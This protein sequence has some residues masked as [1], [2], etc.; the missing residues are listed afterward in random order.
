MGEFHNT[1]TRNES[2]QNSSVVLAVSALTKQ[3]KKK[4]TAPPRRLE[5]DSILCKKTGDVS[6]FWKKPHQRRIRD[7]V[8]AADGKINCG[9][10]KVKYRGTF[11]NDQSNYLFDEKKI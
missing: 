2:K 9:K 5:F 3:R 7:E 11:Q 6:E 8:G 1:G 4:K 10:R